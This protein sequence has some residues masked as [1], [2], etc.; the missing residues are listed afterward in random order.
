[1][2]ERHVAQLTQAVTSVEQQF[3]AQAPDYYEAVEH[4]RTQRAAEL[5]ALGVDPQS[6]QQQAH[7]ELVRHAYMSAQAGM[8][9]AEQAYRIAKARGF[10]GKQQQSPADKLQSQA[11]GVAAARTL[12]SGGATKNALSLDALAA[13]SD[14]DFAEATKGN[15]WQK[16]MGG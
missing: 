16:L 13:M 2:Q 11:K 15:N 6:A 14:E 12:G 5:E 4:L 8:N 9:P 10:T 3:A 1:M 7:Q